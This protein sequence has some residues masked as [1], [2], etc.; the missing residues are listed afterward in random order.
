MRDPHVVALRYRLETDRLLIFD[1]PPPLAHDTDAC[2]LRL[3]NGVLT[4]RMKAHYASADEART[5]A[6]PVI[7]SWELDTALCQGRREI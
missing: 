2:T 1:N 6:D 7:L 4:C 3:A 5:I